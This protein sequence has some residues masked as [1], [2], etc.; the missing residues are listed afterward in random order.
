[1]FRHYNSSEGLVDVSF[2]SWYPLLKCD[3]GKIFFSG[4]N[5]LNLFNPADVEDDPTPPQVIIQNVSLFNRPDEK[6]EYEGFIS[7]L[8][9][10]SLSY[11]QNDLKL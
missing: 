10:L 11:N 8:K 2:Y 4:K 7:E 5:G 1:M 6:I 9:E 3:D